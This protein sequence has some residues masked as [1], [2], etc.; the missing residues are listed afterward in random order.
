MTDLTQLT[1]IIE[2]LDTDRVNITTSIES[3]KTK[4]DDLD[5]QKTVL[6]EQIEN[7]EKALG[8]EEEKLKSLDE[9]IAE[10]KEGYNKIMESTKMLLDIVSVKY[11]TDVSNN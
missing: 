1:Q 8:R 7:N 4:K 3:F 9:T 10:V 2:K 5:Q 11:N 6:L